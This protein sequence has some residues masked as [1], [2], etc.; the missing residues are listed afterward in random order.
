MTNLNQ[1]VLVFLAAFSKIV[2][3]SNLI[4]LFHSTLKYSSETS[5]PK[6]I[7]RNASI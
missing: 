5:N 4:A 7:I 2:E 1:T 3:H 6:I